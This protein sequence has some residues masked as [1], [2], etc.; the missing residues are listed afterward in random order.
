MHFETPSSEKD[1]RMAW[2]KVAFARLK[3]FSIFAISDGTLE[4]A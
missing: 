2:R 4:S 3:P 1:L